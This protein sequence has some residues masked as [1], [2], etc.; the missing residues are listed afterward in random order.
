MEWPQIVLVAS[1]GFGGAVALLKLI[2]RMEKKKSGPIAQRQ[3]LF[4]NGDK[5]EVLK[6]LE[7]LVQAD[8]DRRKE[9]LDVKSDLETMA[10]QIEANSLS[11]QKFGVK[12]DRV[13]ARL[14]RAG[15]P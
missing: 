4:L 11:T 9:H 7:R 6:Q 14:D 8:R 3:P 10:A 12:I 5:E 1:S 13:G 2:D 15:I